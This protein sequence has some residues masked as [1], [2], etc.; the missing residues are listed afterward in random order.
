[1]AR[2]KGSPK[3][4]APPCVTPLHLETVELLN[5]L[6]NFVGIGSIEILMP[7]MAGS[8]M[9]SPDRWLWLEPPEIQPRD[10]T[11]EFYLHM[12]VASY[13][14][15]RC[16]YKMVSTNMARVRV[17]YLPS[18]VGRGLISRKDKSIKKYLRKIMEVIDVSRE[19]WRG[20]PGAKMVP[21]VE[22]DKERSSLFWMFNTMDSPNPNPNAPWIRDENIKYLL[23]RVLN[24]ESIAGMK[25]KPY[26][27]Q[28]RSIA[29]MLQRE[30]APSKS[31]DSRLKTMFAPSGE[32]YYMDQVTCELFQEPSYYEDVRGGI[33]AEEMGYGKTLICLGVILS[34]QHQYA[35]VPEKYSL[36]IP[37]RKEAPS[38]M[39][40]CV[41]TIW[42]Y[43]VPWREHEEALGES[44]VKAIKKN[45][46][47]YEV[48]PVPRSRSNR[49]ATDD[50]KER[51]L[52]GSGTIVVCPPNLVDQW[53]SE[54]AKHVE[55]GRLK[56]LVLAHSSARIPPVQE[57]LEYDIVLFSRTRFDQEE[58]EGKDHAG[59]RESGGKPLICTCPYIGATRT[60]ACLCFRK[61]AVY[62]SP[63][64]R[65]RWRRLIIDEGHSMGS[66]ARKSQ[67]V[68]VAERLPVEARWIVSGTP[69]PSLLG[70]AAGVASTEGE[71]EAEIEERKAKLLND[72]KE[73]QIQETQDLERLGRIV[74]DFLRLQPWAP[75]MERGEQASWAT[76]ARIASSMCVHNIL[77]Q[78][79][80]RH[81]QEDIEK[82]VVLPPLWHKQVYLS[83][84]YSEKLAI[85]LFVGQLA[86][87]AVTSERTDKDYMF[88]PD[89]RGQLRV[90]VN[91]LYKQ[92]SFFWAG[93][94]ELDVIKTME[95]S[96]KYLQKNNCGSDDIVLLQQAI[97][98]CRQAL[99]SESWSIFAKYQD[100]GYFVAGL[101]EGCPETWCF[102]PLSS[103]PLMLTAAPILEMQKH[104]SAH[105][106]Q[107]ESILSDGL[108]NL[109][110]RFMR[111][112]T[113]DIQRRSTGS[114]GRKRGVPGS[115]TSTRDRRVSM[116]NRE[117]RRALEEEDTP[118]DIPVEQRAVSGSASQHSSVNM[119]K[120]KPRSV[121]KGNS[122]ESIVEGQLPADSPLMHAKILGTASTKLSYLLD[123]ILSHYTTEK[124]LVFYESDNV[125]WYIAQALDIMGI[126][127]LAYQRN[128][129]G[130]KKA[131]YLVT[132]HNSER[133]RV[134][135]MDLTQAAHGLNVC[136]ASRIYFVNPVWTPSIEAQALKRAH[137]I[138]QTK[139]VYAETLILEG[140]LE[141]KMVKRRNSMTER[142]LRETRDSIANDSEMR[143]IISNL[144]FLDVSDDEGYGMNQI[145]QFKIAQPMFGAG[146]RGGVIDD[147]EENLLEVE[148]F[149]DG[150]ARKRSTRKTQNSIPR[151]SPIG[152]DSGSGDSAPEISN[153]SLTVSNGKR[154]VVVID[155]PEESA[156]KK[157]KKT[158]R[159]G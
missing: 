71:T 103:S 48:P 24:S 15:A 134:L 33:L 26:E 116:E 131:Q 152:G 27:Y 40:L 81:R 68:C 2:P 28:K 121:L 31:V 35:Q 143:S 130:Q 45:H 108:Q 12:L 125:A 124:T 76:Y 14:V 122:S 17:Y 23:Q 54:I 58:K 100:M 129:P 77:R 120:H 112:Y 75:S 98:S 155:E 135:L 49:Y 138:G 83:P 78:L 42:K 16:T 128:L 69:S 91:N 96:E 94:T 99:R 62:K 53:R 89:N 60:P 150:S 144:G 66:G 3:P 159:F 86:V 72:R 146:K 151:P 88:H 20:R 32:V 132:F 149:E 70:A 9:E 142:E 59:R 7:R 11:I 74:R 109:G 123:S 87:N 111:K 65:I 114:G 47:F 102:E 82:S 44:C 141:D 13:R 36:I 6:T 25:S 113:E 61:E 101:P 84:K 1:M 110:T 63:I 133:F 119:G 80:V 57:L 85:N 21:I 56:V 46:G 147:P 156:P 118:L 106:Y 34:T 90:L 105:A 92:S 52:L 140:T 19:G 148:G 137:R 107:E 67:G 93:F 41:S 145:A 117:I 8:G 5:D 157:K 136:S 39:D 29:M 18:D 38:L 79:M 55:S 50:T 153:R 37:L 97:S 10:G 43:S 154:V 95:V 127:Y 64:N 73:F 22:P 115:S 158:V 4:Q 139:P 30:L 104:V 126:E 51:I